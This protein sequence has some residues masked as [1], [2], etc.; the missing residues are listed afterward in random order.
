M[1]RA[2][3]LGGDR[4]GGGPS[5]REQPPQ[6]PSAAAGRRRRG[7][8]RRAEPGRDLHRQANQALRL[9]GNFHL[10]SPLSPSP[11]G[12]G[13]EEEEEEAELL[14]LFV[15]FPRFLQ[16]RASVPSPGRGHAGSP[17]VV[18]GRGSSWAGLV[19]S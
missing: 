19:P 11:V 17:R 4:S 12:V 10:A 13:G 7:G 3:H 2:P 14:G 9:A 1:E 6:G 18:M 8:G 16:S 5:R 15:A